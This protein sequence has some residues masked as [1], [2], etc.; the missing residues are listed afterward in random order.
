MQ[1]IYSTYLIG[2]MLAMILL[3]HPTF[4]QENA[5]YS[6]RNEL[7]ISM[8][9]YASRPSGHVRFDQ[10]FYAHPVRGV[11]YKR[12]MSRSA[13]RLAVPSKTH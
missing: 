2:C 7:G 12:H 11:S 1:T 9:N 13:V 6:A 10:T 4:G 5:A 3:I 8:L